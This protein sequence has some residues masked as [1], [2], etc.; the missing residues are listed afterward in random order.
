VQGSGG[1]GIIEDREIYYSWY[2]MPGYSFDLLKILF[3]SGT[4]QRIRNKRM[5]KDTIKAVYIQKYLEAS[6]LP[7]NS[8]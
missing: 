8:S 7:L 1:I 2:R 4:S 3:D 5:G 6:M